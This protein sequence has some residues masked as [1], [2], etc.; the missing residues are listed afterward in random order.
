M[1][2]NSDF[3]YHQ[4]ADQIEKLI[5]DSVYKLGDKI[6]S[7]RQ[8]SSERGISPSSVFQAYYYLEAK[9]L[10]EA[11]PKSGYYVSHN[12]R[13]TPALP[14]MGSTI[15]K[16]RFVS[17]EDMISE[18]YH[19]LADP[20]VTKFSLAAPA[21]DLLPAAKLN[22]AMIQAIRS[23]PFS[24]LSYEDTHG[25]KALRKQLAR[26]AISWKG[27]FSEDE[28][29]VTAGCMEA[30]NL[31][32]RAVTEP[33]DLVAIE[34]PTYFGIFQ[35]IQNLGLRA[36]AVPTNPLTGV[37]LPAFEK[38]LETQ[39]VKA[40]L[41]VPNFNNPLGSCMPDEN[42]E[43]LVK[44]LAK[45]GI[46]LIEDDIYGD[47]YFGKKRPL[48]CKSFDKDGMVL[49]CS[50]LSKSLAPGYRIGWCI[51][52]KYYDQINR[53]KMVWTVTGT[54]ITQAAVAIFLENGRYEHHLRQFRKVLHTQSMRYAQEIAAVF[55][56]GIRISRPDGGFV[57]WIELPLG[58][59]A[60][61]LYQDAMKYGI[62]IAPGQIFSADA[63]YSHYIRLG[64]GQT[65]TPQIKDSLVKLG[66]LITNTLKSS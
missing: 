39:P 41:F 59:D 47:L 57:L 55:P 16:G 3:L 43:K 51:P 26:L 62:S 27:A 9:G 44:M 24:G 56:P 10:I 18:V 64:F 21:I 19:D 32:L 52:G 12:P 28:I 29:I 42:K 63:H 14:R 60:F 8:L 25:N 6:P 65:F 2:T 61:Q 38:I 35:A 17:V 5:L 37:E 15:S 36:I 22:K 34:C 20:H 48:T 33:G 58:I 4:I 1:P 46:P 7:V 23:H 13:K 45:R 66:K 54:T 31:C 49:Y 50:S 53:L 40:C 11:R 30:L